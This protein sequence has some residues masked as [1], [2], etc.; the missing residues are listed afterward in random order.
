MRRVTVGEILDKA[1]GIKFLRR[2]DK[3]AIHQEEEILCRTV[4]WAIANGDIRGQTARTMA[5]LAVTTDT[6]KVRQDAEY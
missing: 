5:H 4:L 6:L 1:E 2:D 3:E